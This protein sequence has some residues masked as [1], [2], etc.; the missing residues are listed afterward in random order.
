MNMVKAVCECKD[1]SEDDLVVAIQ[2]R[3]FAFLDTWGFWIWLGVFILILMTGGFW[4]VVVLVY[5]FDEIIRPKY[6]CSQCDEIVL[7]K[8]FRL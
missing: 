8:Q 3:R 6:Y 5:H 7:P 1:F 2:R 4:I